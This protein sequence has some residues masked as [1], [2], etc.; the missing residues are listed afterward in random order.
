MA[1]QSSD[2]SNGRFLTGPIILLAS[3][4][5][6][7]GMLPDLFG[8]LSAA[9]LAIPVF[10]VLKEFGT[11][12][13]S[14]GIRNSVILAVAAAIVLNQVPVLLFSLT[15]IPLGYSLQ[16]SA[17]AGDDEIITIG[18]GILVLG[19]S[20][21][22]FWSI[23]GIIQGINP[24]ASLIDTLDTDF[25]QAYDIYSKEGKLPA[26]TLVSLDQIV[27]EL[28]SIIPKIMPGLLACSVLMTV[29]LNLVV[30]NSLWQRLL[31]GQSPWRK[32]S[33]WRLPDNL[34][35]VPIAASI[36]LIIGNGIVSNAGICIIIVASMIYFFQGLA[37]F[38]YFLERW[39]VPVY[40]RILIYVIMVL[41]SYGLLILIIVGFA[42][43]W[44]NFRQRFN[45][46]QQIDN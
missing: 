34:V 18:K 3:A 32:Y 16:R 33:D 36:T 46:E 26:E 40:L 14:I 41:Q 15:L 7:P 44:V 23:F 45:G 28:R 2:Y 20:W 19:L 30:A 27:N 11:H 4:F 12:R 10:Y 38:L 6:L 17:A 5:L 43:V 31:P 13:G 22:V 37:V 8:W 25:V 24:Y 21:L 9:L 42:D 35:W 1:A 29:W 39:K